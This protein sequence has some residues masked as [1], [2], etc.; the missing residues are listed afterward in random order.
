[1]IPT[2]A[3]GVE[4]NFFDSYDGYAERLTAHRIGYL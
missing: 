1:M 2:Q 4:V 3:Q